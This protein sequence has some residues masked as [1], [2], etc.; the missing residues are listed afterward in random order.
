MAGFPA[1]NSRGRSLPQ[2]SFDEKKSGRVHAECLDKE[3]PPKSTFAMVYSDVQLSR[4]VAARMVNIHYAYAI[5]L[6]SFQ[7]L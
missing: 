7:S 3:G 2:W 4:S 1:S 6:N 5:D